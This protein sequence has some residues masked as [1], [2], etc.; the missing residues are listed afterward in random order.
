MLLCSLF[1]AALFPGCSFLS[2]DVAT[3]WT[4]VP[5]IAAYAEI[6]NGLGDEVRINVVYKDHPDR[7]T[8]GAAPPDVIIGP[9]LNS[10]QHITLFMPLDNL[11]GEDGMQESDFYAGVLSL[12]EYEN[13]KVLL[14]LSFNLEGLMIK[15]GDKGISSTLI[16]LDQ[17]QT[18]SAGYN[19]KPE[20]KYQT[21]GFSPAWT[22]NAGM[23]LARL[24][25]VDFRENAIGT[26][27]W[28]EDALTQAVDYARTW[29]RDTNGGF[30]KDQEFIQK[31]LY[32]PGHKLLNT[33]PPRIRFFPTTLS[34]FARLPSQDRDPLDIVWLHH[35]EKIE[36]LEN[37][38]FAGIL[39]QS[40]VK[41]IAKDFLV[42][43]ASEQTQKMLLES[44]RFKRIRT[45]GIANGLST[46]ITI[47][48][49]T[50]PRYYPF[51]VGRIPPSKYLHFPSAL[52]SEWQQLLS[53]V[54]NPWIQVKLNRENPSEDTL[55]E[56]I[57]KWYLQQPNF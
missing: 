47:N 43:L 19:A 38:V 52:P 25:N 24:M 41:P 54:V 18:L 44:A 31:Y 7:L 51:L 22:Q 13:E 16:S 55:P 28:N 11:F 39:K 35:E 49:N 45:F 29:I 48:E 33:S 34:S 46:L 12:G 57:R 8:E 53:D 9:N 40:K 23:M 14:P 1:A 15:K 30:S 50:F 4:N 2:P 5:E 26:L 17:M 37:I 6:Y 3:V 20:A 10:I 56:Q 36:V 27:I 21:M 32:D 42:W